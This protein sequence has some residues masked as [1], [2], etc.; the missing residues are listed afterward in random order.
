MIRI[1]VVD[2]HAILCEGLS[3]ILGQQDDIVVVGSAKD[4]IEARQLV[5]ELSPDVVLMDVRMPGGDGIEATEAIKRAH[6]EVK[7]LILST[8]EEP[9]YVRGV[10]AAGGDGYLLKAL[11]DDQLCAGIR[12]VHAGMAAFDDTVMNC[13]RDEGGSNRIALS[14][15]EESILVAVMHGETN[16]EIVRRTGISL[17][18]VKALVS[19]LLAKAGVAKRAE[20]TAWAQAVYFSGERARP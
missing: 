14:S 3:L 19:L 17:G 1:L 5:E 10:L 4:G 7:V 11:G 20:L 18:T 6:P 16:A 12:A 8:F 13:L 15:R 9:E 2:D